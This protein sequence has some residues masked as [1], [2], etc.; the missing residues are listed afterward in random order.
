MLAPFALV[1]CGTAREQGAPERTAASTAA[2]QTSVTAPT[3]IAVDADAGTDAD[4]GDGGTA[5]TAERPAPL[6]K[7]EG[8]LARFYT[9]LDA[10]KAGTR[11]DHVRILWL[12]DSHGQADFWSGKLR[13]ILQ[14]RFGNGG[15]GFVHLGYKGY[16]HDGVEVI[17]K[18]KWSIAPKN[19]A[20]SNKAGDGIFGLG[21]VLM[22]PKE[23]GAEAGVEIKDT[24]LTGK[25]K[26]DLCVRFNRAGDEITAN[27]TGK[28][29]I[30]LKASGKASERSALV[31]SPFAT[32]P[33]EKGMRLM[34]QPSAGYPSLCGVVIETDPLESPGVVLDV[35]GIN[36]A[37][38]TTALGWNEEAWTAEFMRRSPELVIFE[39]GTNESGDVG[40]KAEVYEERAAKLVERVRNKKPDIDCA[41]LAPTER[42]DQEERSARIRD[43]LKAAAKTNK[44]WFWDTI[45]VMGGKGSMR[46]WTLENPPKGAK[47]GVHLTV[48]GYYSL[49]ER[50][51]DDLMQKY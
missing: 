37:R 18:E 41:I 21:G 48:R 36:G 15:P 42:S 12:G 17:I 9:A 43:I 1:H 50:L 34:V 2:A 5:E 29:P 16:R 10:L 46:K 38:Y 3:T 35:A 13:S 6:P 33:V 26:W 4:A 40:I 32:D 44:C 25:L 51:A 27:I 14:K 45:D 19:P 7:R 23:P 30:K 22:T 20:A 28:K 24:S 11:K 31:H 39:Y 49:G 8:D 47:D